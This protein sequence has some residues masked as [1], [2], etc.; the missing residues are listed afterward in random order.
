MLRYEV[1]LLETKVKKT[2]NGCL[3]VVISKFLYLGSQ[4]HS[5]SFHSR[6][7]TV[8]FILPFLRHPKIQGNIP[9]NK[10]TLS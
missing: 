8:Y 1:K 2:Q 10:I 5:L 4:Q 6:V 3:I 7:F 9:K